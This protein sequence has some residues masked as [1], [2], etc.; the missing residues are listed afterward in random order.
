MYI[1]KSKYIIYSIYS[2]TI[3]SDG[4]S[5]RSGDWYGIDGIYF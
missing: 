1:L 3:V 4:I 2:I 5:V